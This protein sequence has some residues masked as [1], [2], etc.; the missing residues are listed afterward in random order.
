M[1]HFF[2]GI[3]LAIVTL[4]SAAKADPQADQKLRDHYEMIVSSLESRYQYETIVK[5][6][7]EAL[8]QFPDDLN[9]I[10]PLGDALDRLGRHTEADKVFTDFI[11]SKTW[12]DDPSLLRVF[13]QYHSNLLRQRRNT[14][15]AAILQHVRMIMI[16]QYQIQPVN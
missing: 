12:K 7:R 11:A 6:A 10:I 16:A 9:L 1:R 14:E 15:A 8:A 3:L 13:M 2:A 5:T 4:P